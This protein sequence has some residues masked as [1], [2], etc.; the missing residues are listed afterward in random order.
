MSGRSWP[1]VRAEV[2][3]DEDQ[4]AVHREQMLAEI[5]EFRRSDEDGKQQD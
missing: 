2:D 1:D 4:V 3:L 5:E